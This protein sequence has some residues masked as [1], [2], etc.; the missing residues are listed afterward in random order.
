M[1]NSVLFAS[2]LASAVAVLAALTTPAMADCSRL[3]NFA[4]VQAA[5]KASTKPSGGES[6][7]GLDLNMWASVVDRGGTV[8]VVTF[9]GKDRGA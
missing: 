5:L 7:G 6:N 1:R 3:P 8:C 9:T 2:A 4:K